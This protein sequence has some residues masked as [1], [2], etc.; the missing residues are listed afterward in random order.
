VPTIPPG[1]LLALVSCPLARPWPFLIGRP[2]LWGQRDREN[3]VP[4]NVALRALADP[5]LLARVYLPAVCIV[6]WHL[7]L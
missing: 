4:P 2:V 1:P 6:H 5:E 3:N 7:V